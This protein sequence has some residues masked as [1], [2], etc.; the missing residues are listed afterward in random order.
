MQRDPIER[1]LVKEPVGKVFFRY[2]IPSLVG[3]LL[4]SVNVVIDG[5]F[6]GHAVGPIALAGVNIST[7]MFSLYFSISLLIGIG[8]GALYSMA[9]GRK[10]IKTAQTIFTHAFWF[11]VIVLVILSC[12]SYLFIHDIALLLGANEQTLPYVIE[13]LTIILIFGIFIG[14][15]VLLSIFVRN[16]GNPN[17]AMVANVVMAVF[18]V[19]LNYILIF[20]FAWGVK[21]SACATVCSQLIGILVLVFHFFR[22]STTLR[23][24]RPSFQASLF[25]RIMTI[26]FPSFTSE[27]GLAVFTFGYNLAMVKTVGT[28]G[29]SAFS[30]VNYLHTMMLMVFIGL[31]SAVQPLI[32]FYYGA[33]LRER[34][35]HTVKIAEKTALF[36]GVF[37]LILGC[38]LAD[39]LVSLFGGMTK[40]LHSLAVHGLRLFFVGYLFIGINFVYMNYYQS[41]GQVR[42]SMVITLLRGFVL[43]SGFLWIQPMLFGIN[44]VWLSVPSAEFAVAL[45]IVI[46]MRKATL[47]EIEQQ[48]HFLA[49]L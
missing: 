39:P 21:G 29:V 43:L 6:V 22:K 18:N 23:W 15:Q 20:Q 47:K 36:L 31:G 10:D 4:M 7:P 3:M 46:F 32:S 34:M 48:G 19:L 42:S 16:D 26:G 12:I 27:I 2:L 14:I 11:V 24:G 45:F 17:L 41:V 33:K 37:S 13:F 5:I 38:L 44:G 40:E 8:G 30:I 28:I 35:I 25:K 49:D 9:I 1:Q